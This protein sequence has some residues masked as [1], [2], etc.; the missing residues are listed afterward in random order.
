MIVNNENYETNELYLEA[1]EYAQKY[2][3]PDNDHIPTYNQTYHPG[4]FVETLIIYLLNKCR[5][6]AITNEGLERQN[7]VLLLQLKSD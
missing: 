7:Q 5:E 3:R 6:L 1:F 2:N 4:E